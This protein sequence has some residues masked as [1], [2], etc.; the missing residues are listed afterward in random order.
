MPVNQSSLATGLSRLHRHVYGFI[1]QG[2]TAYLLAKEQSKIEPQPLD[3]TIYEQMKKIS[4][5]S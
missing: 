4:L 2:H 5:N 1:G 3:L